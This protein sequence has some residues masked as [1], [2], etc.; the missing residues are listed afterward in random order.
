MRFKLCDEDKTKL[1]MTL[2]EREIQ[3]YEGLRD[4]N[5]IEDNKLDRHIHEGVYEILFNGMKVKLEVSLK[6]I[7]PSGFIAEVQANGVILNVVKNK[8]IRKTD[9]YREIVRRFIEIKNNAE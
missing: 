9:V 8:P 3:R 6:E 7:S 2:S 4:K 1:I 5:V